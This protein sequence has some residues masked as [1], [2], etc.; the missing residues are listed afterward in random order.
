MLYLY[1]VLVDAI[2]GFSHQV[3]VTLLCRATINKTSESNIQNE[4]NLK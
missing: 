1:S 4:R 3:G 2:S